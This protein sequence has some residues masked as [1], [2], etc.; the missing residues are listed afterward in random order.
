TPPDDPDTAA[1]VEVWRGQLGRLAVLEVLG[2]YPEGLK[3]ASEIRAAADR[4]RYPPLMAEAAL[5][6]GSLWMTVA[7]PEEAEL[8]LT[9]ALKL[10]LVHGLDVV[11]AEAAAKRIFVLGDGLGRRTA[12]LEAEVVA[13]AL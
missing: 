7:R 13:E 6:E 11:A 2:K 3:L 4:L 8:A 5:G 1:Q 9:E 12:A 10:A